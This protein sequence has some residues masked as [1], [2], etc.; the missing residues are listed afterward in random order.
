MANSSMSERILAS[1]NLQSTVIVCALWKQSHWPEKTSQ[2]FSTRATD[3][4]DRLLK[5][6]LILIPIAVN[7]H[8]SL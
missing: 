3:E 4:E 7:C 6:E 1:S 5:L 2:T 8:C